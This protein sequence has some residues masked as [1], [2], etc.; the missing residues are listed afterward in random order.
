MAKQRT[1]STAFWRDPYIASLPPDGKLLF[2]YC[3]SSPDSNLCGVYPC[4]LAIIIADTGIKENRVLALFKFFEND[5]KIRYYDGWI[6]VKNR[7]KHQN[8]NN[9]QIQ[10]GIQK[11]LSS[12][13]EI[14]KKWVADD[15]YMSHEN[16]HV[17]KDIDISVDVKEKEDTFFR[18]NYF[19]VTVKQHEKYVSAY[20]GIDFVGEYNRMSV[21]LDNNKNKRKSDYPR[22]INNWLSRQ[23]KERAAKNTPKKSL[24]RDLDAEAE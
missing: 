19:A 6:A 15:S 21:W 17:D 14:L 18:C 22:F 12:A 5:K 16:K 11:E 7:I 20:P 23:Y 9:E 4:P 8:K 13:P 2:D 24:Y 3:M 1:K 10:I